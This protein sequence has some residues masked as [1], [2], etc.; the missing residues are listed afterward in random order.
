[1]KNLFLH[2]TAFIICFCGFAQ[3]RTPQPSPGTE[4]HQTIGLTE[5]ILKYSRPSM[6]GRKVFGNLVPFN[7]IWRT[8]ANSNSIISFSDVVQVEGKVLSPGQYAIYSKPGTEYWDVYFY[9]DTNN[10]GLPTEWDANK[11]AAEV[12]VPVRTLVSP[13]ETFEISIE[14]LTNND[15]HLVMSWENTAVHILI[16]V[17]SKEKAM[18]SIEAT[19]PGDGITANDYFAA[20]SYYQDENIDLNQAKVWIDKALYMNPEPY[21]MLRRKAL[22]YAAIGD[23]EGAIAAAKLS[24]AAAEKAGNAD[25]VKLN[26]DSLKD[27]G[28][29]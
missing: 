14:D 20:A 24:M 5:V 7:Q 9:S 28:A 27:W 25:Y 4:I 15:A 1:M 19:M 6:R 29:E 11:I 13:V 10:S 16:A 12:K 3:I 8:G 17:P 26:Q 21:W 18:A 23:R 2:L 22:I